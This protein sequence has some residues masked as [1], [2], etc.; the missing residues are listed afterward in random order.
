MPSSPTP[1]QVALASAPWAT[2][3]KL[4]ETDP[5]NLRLRAELFERALA[6]GALD[7]AAS[8]LDGALA[9]DPLG[10]EWRHRKAVLSMARGDWQGAEAQLQGLI[11][12]GQHDPGLRYNLAYTHFALGESALANALL[13]E[14]MQEQPADLMDQV[15][16]LRLRCLH[17]EHKLQEGVA[18]YQQFEA[19]HASAS[20][21]GTAALMAVD[22]GQPAL[23]NAWAS[24]ALA[25]N[26]QQHEALV[27]KGSVLLGERQGSQA[28]PLL[29]RA[30]RGHPRDGRTLSALGL[31]HM[32]NGNFAEAQM[33]LHRAV[34]FMPGHIGTWHAIGWCAIFM[35]DLAAAQLAFE[36]AISLDRNFAESQGGL[37]VTLAL[38]G[39]AQSA[40]ETLRRAEG[41]PGRSVSADYAAAILGGET[42]DAERFEKMARRILGAQ[43]DA[44]GRS[45]ADLI[46][47]P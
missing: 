27:A 37:A 16:T 46:L 13:V 22:L 14:L 21:A 2:L 41:L 32:L 24:R 7:V 38:R 42:Q 1:S 4:L 6:A 36:E 20:T 15:L 45:L 11:N 40:R 18:L 33:V 8:A 47:R 43:R 31:A 12:E 3:A 44:E 35:R 19:Q 39:Q 28:L 5:S 26:P 17:Q 29:V 9:I 30:E 34:Q 10:A 25:M 23:A